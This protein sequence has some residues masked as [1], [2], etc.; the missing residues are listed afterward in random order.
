MCARAQV[1]IDLHHC[2]LFVFTLFCTSFRS[3]TILSVFSM[4]AHGLYQSLFLTFWICLAVKSD[5]CCSKKCAHIYEID[6]WNLIIESWFYLLIYLFNYVF[7]PFLSLSYFLSI[8]LILFFQ[9]FYSYPFSRTLN[10]SHSL[11]FSRPLSFSVILSHFYLYLH[12]Y[13]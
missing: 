11:W 2:F 6:N 7:F 3:C 4:V 10:L 1:K 13:M 5:N 9:S 12:L 8:F